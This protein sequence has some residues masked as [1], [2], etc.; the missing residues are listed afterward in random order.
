MQQTLNLNW[1]ETSNQTQ[2]QQQLYASAK[3]SS[4]SLFMEDKKSS[5]LNYML[6][7][8]CLKLCHN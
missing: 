7:D 4:L 1:D 2:F 5:L 3:H 6:S 8:V